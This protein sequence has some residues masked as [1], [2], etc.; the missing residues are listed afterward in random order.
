MT[1]IGNDDLATLAIEL[2]EDF[3]DLAYRIRH[4]D[5]GIDG[6]F[7]DRWAALFGEMQRIKA[8][9]ADVSALPPPERQPFEKPYVPIYL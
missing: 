5:A 8:Q 7:H 2:R 6:T 4:G 3:D 1:A 9:L